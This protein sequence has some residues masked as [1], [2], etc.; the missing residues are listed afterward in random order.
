MLLKV[1]KVL[2]ASIVFCIV[3]IVLVRIGIFSPDDASLKAKYTNEFSRFVEIDG[4]PIHYRDE[5][6][7]PVLVLV[8]AHLGSLHMWDGWV[9]ELGK[10]YRIVRFTYPPY[11]LSGQDTTGIYGASRALELIE[12]VIDHIG[13]HSFSIAGTSSGSII[14]AR[15]AAKH[16]GRVEKL[17]LSTVPAYTPGDRQAPPLSFRVMM[18]LSNNVLKIYRPEVY[19]R[20]FLEYIYGDPALVTLEKVQRYTDLNNRSGSIANTAKFIMTNAQSSVNVADILGQVQTPTLIQWAGKSPVLSP[21]GLD[22][23]LPMF[24]EAAVQAIRYPA[25]GHALVMEDPVRTAAAAHEFLQD[26]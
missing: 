7:G 8:H 2:S 11:G 20:M 22:E 23:V 14:A 4:V 24:T 1:G 19:W 18:W 10:H 26:N 13:L 9:C 3:A 21:A 12:G 17:L 5:G 16:P 15:Y 25:L 6:E